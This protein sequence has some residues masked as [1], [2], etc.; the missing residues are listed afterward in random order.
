M[1]IIATN[2][3][4]NNSKMSSPVLSVHNYI[5]GKFVPHGDDTRWIESCN[6]ATGEVN[7]RLPDSGAIEVQLAVHAAREAFHR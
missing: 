6:P 2:N 3:N 7:A 5:N 4:N 1:L